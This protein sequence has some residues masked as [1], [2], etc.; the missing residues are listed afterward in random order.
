MNRLD[1][2]TSRLQPVLL[3]VLGVIMVPLGVGSL[4]MGASDGISVVPVVLGLAMLATFT[5]VVWL[6][7]RAHGRSVRYFSDEGLERNDGQRLAWTDLERVVHQVRIDPSRPSDRK[8]WRTEIWFRDGR[9]AWLVP[10][11]IGNPREVGEF[12]SRLPCEHAEKVV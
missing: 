2:E 12:V 3:V 5:G 7:R 11:R 1:V 9:S 10:L 8:L 6:G 4:I